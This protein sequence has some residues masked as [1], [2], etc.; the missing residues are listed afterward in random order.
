VRVGVKGCVGPLKDALGFGNVP[1][2]KGSRVPSLGSPPDSRS[3]QSCGP[4]LS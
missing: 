1:L 2:R 3:P 4:Y